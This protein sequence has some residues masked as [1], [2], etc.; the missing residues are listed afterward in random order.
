MSIANSDDI[1]FATKEVWRPVH[2]YVAPGYQIS[3]EVKT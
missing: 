2:I 1:I 3:E